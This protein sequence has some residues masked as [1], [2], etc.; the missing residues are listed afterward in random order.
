MMMRLLPLLVLAATVFAATL[1]AA[2][3]GPYL[4][5]RG[6]GTL[7]TDSE[8]RSSEGSFDLSY[9]PGGGG[10]IAIGYDLADAFPE[11]GQGRIEVEGGYHTLPVDKIGD[12]PASGDVTVQTLMLNTFAEYFNR[13]PWVPYIGI[14]AG[15]AE[16]ALD[17][18]TLPAMALADDKDDVFAYQAGLGLGLKAGEHVILDLGYRYFGTLDPEFKRTDGSTVKSDF[19]SHDLL[20]G[21]RL[22]F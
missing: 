6:F 5:L 19:S 18:S 7:A 12:A 15:Y 21:L 13:S 20:L 2:Q 3:P 16:I 8:T 9:D 4:E 10:S 17:R 22:Q 11:L 14:G 1:A